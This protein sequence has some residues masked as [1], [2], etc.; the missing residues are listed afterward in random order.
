MPP[1]A[2]RGTRTEQSD[3][4]TTTTNPLKIKNKKKSTNTQRGPAGDVPGAHHPLDRGRGGALPDGAQGTGLLTKTVV[5]DLYV[6]V[7]S[8]AFAVR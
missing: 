1:H 7:C 3:S 5:I 4:K 6:F 8:V 2:R